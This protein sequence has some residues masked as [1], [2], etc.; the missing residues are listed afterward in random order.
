[1]SAA[2]PLVLVCEDG[3][4]YLQRFSRFL[5]EELELVRVDDEASALA[6]C[7]RG[8]AALLFDLDFSRLPPEKL[9]D[10]SGQRG[11]RTRDESRRLAQMQGILILRALRAAGVRTPAFLFADLDDPGRVRFLETSLAPLA[12]VPSSE[13]M[14]AIRAR[15]VR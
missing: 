14:A 10:E 6:A 13:G 15:L 12:V 4:E 9:I 11:P 2:R 1:V 8:P 3:H 5:G 7:A